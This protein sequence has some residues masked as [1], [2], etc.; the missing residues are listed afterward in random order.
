MFYVV[1]RWLI[2]RLLTLNGCLPQ[3]PLSQ[4][5]NSMF[6]VLYFRQMHTYVNVMYKCMDECTYYLSN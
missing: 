3:R 5:P 4:I 1:K 2:D 6:V